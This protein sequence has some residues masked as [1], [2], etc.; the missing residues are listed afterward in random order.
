[1]GKAVN[2]HSKEENGIQ[3]GEKVLKHQSNQ[4][5]TNKNEKLIYRPQNSKN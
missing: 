1:M 5:N 2:R 4:T 3:F